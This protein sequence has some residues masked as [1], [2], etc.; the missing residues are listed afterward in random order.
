MNKLGWVWVGGEM[1]RMGGG[2]ETV[3]QIYCIKIHFNKTY[4]LYC[5]KTSKTLKLYS[6]LHH[7]SNKVSLG[8]QKSMNRPY[9]S[10][11]SNSN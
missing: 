6:L 10:K 8:I 1:G 9:L 7:I 5:K 2:G 4:F 3:I 11:L